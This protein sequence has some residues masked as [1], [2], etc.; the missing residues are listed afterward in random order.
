VNDR[1]RVDR[2]PPDEVDAEEIAE[3]DV[4]DQEERQTESLPDLDA[5]MDVENDDEPPPIATSTPPK[6]PPPKKKTKGVKVFRSGTVST[7]PPAP[8]AGMPGAAKESD[9]EERTRTPGGI[10]GAAPPPVEKSKPVPK[11][12][13][14][15]GDGPVAPGGVLGARPPGAKSKDLDAP[16][17][18][19]GMLGAAP[20]PAPRAAASEG[21]ASAGKEPEES[22]VPK[23]GTGDEPDTEEGRD[24]VMDGATLGASM[25]AMFEARI[26][27]EADRV[28]KPGAPVTKTV[29]TATKEEPSVVVAGTATEPTVVVGKELTHPASTTEEKGGP[30]GTEPVPAV[31]PLQMPPSPQELATRLEES[32]GP[33]PKSWAVVGAIAV[34]G[35]TAWYVIGTRSPTEPEDTGVKSPV[36]ANEPSPAVA[37]AA[38]GPGG[39]RRRPAEPET[40]AKRVAARKARKPRPRSRPAEPAKPPSPPAKAAPAPEPTAETPAEPPSQ[41][42]RVP[43]TIEPKPAAQV[44]A[45]APETEPEPA[46]PEPAATPAPVPTPATTPPAVADGPAVAPKPAPTTK[47]APAPAVP[48]PSPPAVQP[49]PTA[50]VAEK[51]ASEP[52]AAAADEPAAPEEPAGEQLPDKPSQQEINAALK[53]IRPALKKCAGG[54]SGFAQ[55]ELMVK[56]D[57]RVSYALVDGTFMGKPEG[58]C[59]AREARKARFPPFTNPIHTVRYNI[60]F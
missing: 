53:K 10:L 3:I 56:P 6:P 55:I 18:P 25:K 35:A 49:A 32:K 7:M 42:R 21:A 60:T 27:E 36:T 17:G 5:I 12:P 38:Q 58:S 15:T 46:E 28:V 20:P 8:A 9:G 54:R 24:A 31:P 11:E 57:G 2:A 22:E 40:R 51:P 39:A 23:K 4:A 37:S 50:P 47:P 41:A 30:P 14:G 59:M 29:S 33:V 43:E 44:P 16:S 1:D 19:G 13:E 45:P 34:L 26:E 52:P 48:T